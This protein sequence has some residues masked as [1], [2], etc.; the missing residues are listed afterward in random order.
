[1][2]KN[3]KTIKA[4]AL[5]LL[6]S[7]GVTTSEKFCA[8]VPLLAQM[9]DQLLSLRLAVKEMQ[10]LRNQLCEGLSDYADSHA[11]ALD[12]PLKTVKNDVE[13]GLVT[14]DC[15]TYRYTRSFDGLARPSG[16]NMTQIFLKSLP[17]EWQREKVE[18]NTQYIGNN[19]VSD[20]DLLV[21]GLM[22]KRKRDFK[23]VQTYE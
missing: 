13:E 9:D 6:S 2:R 11:K 21:H 14:I 15:T 18:L 20:E 23:V 7:A 10:N 3:S 22:W 4:E 1:M 17:K 19:D 12:T 5:E 8:G 16:D